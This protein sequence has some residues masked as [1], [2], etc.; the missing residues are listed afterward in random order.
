MG[1]EARRR[2]Q[3][4]ARARP[5]RG[6]GDDRPRRQGVG[7]AGRD[8]ARH[9][10]RARRRPHPDVAEPG[11]YAP[12]HAGTPPVW[13]GR[14]EAD[15][16]PVRALRE[17]HAE[18]EAEEHRR[19][20]YVAL[21]RAED[22]LLICG[23]ARKQAPAAAGTRSAR[24]RRRTMARVSTRRCS[25]RTAP[26]RRAG[27]TPGRRRAGAGRTG[28]G[29]AS[30]R[31]GRR[32]MAP[33][34]SPR[35]GRAARYLALAARR[36]RPGGERRDRRV[37]FL[38][39]AGQGARH[40][41][42]SAVGDPAGTPGGRPRSAGGPARRRCGL[43][44]RRAQDDGRRGACVLAMADAAWLFGPGSRA[45]VPVAAV[46]EDLG[47]GEIHGPHRPVGDRARSG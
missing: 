16:P 39:R 37:R 32:L 30:D 10:R 20:L 43:Q 28:R 9:H 36:R 14:K 15:P 2:D 40:V 8:P 33:S 1:V 22:R 19:L 18:R 45:E 29:A 21:T 5:R 34:P 38:A 27:A 3:A 17:A 26:P 4:R 7:G 11:K 35:R 13:L 12:D 24:P 42:P 31:A 23:A 47:P 46:L 6:A 25:T 41:D 44:Q